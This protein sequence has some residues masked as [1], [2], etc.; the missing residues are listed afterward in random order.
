MSHNFFEGLDR[1]KIGIATTNIGRLL[2]CP[3]KKTLLPRYCLYIC[4]N[5]IFRSAR[6]LSSVVTKPRGC[7][8]LLLVYYSSLKIQLPLWKLDI[9]FTH[10]LFLI[11]RR[12]VV[13]NFSHD[14]WDISQFCYRFT[15]HYQDR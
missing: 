13:D 8:L 2:K 12:H 6:V 3:N 9:S 10:K 7:N 5:G 11:E 14:T 1:L 15:K 4:H